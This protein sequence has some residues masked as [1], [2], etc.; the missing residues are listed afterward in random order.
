MSAAMRATVSPKAR[1]ISSL[2]ASLGS[3]MMPRWTSITKSAPLAEG[4]LQF[5][6]IGCAGSAAYV[7]IALRHCVN[8]ESLSH[9]FLA[10]RLPQ[11]RLLAGVQF[12][13]SRSQVQYI[14][15]HLPLRLDQCDFDIALMLR[16]LRAHTVKQSG[17]V[18]S[19]YLQQRASRRAAV[20]EFNLPLDLDLGTVRL[21]RLQAVAQHTRH[22]GF[23]FDPGHDAFFQTV[24]FLQVHLQRLKAIVEIESVYHR[25]RGIR[26]CIRF[27]DVHSP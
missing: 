16:D 19:D 22:V 6:K 2:R 9:E 17:T 23:A 7:G 8:E 5:N 15:R 13:P 18:L 4:I 20:V 26:K 25:A 10:Q 27:H 24:P 14:N 11:R 21:L 12:C 1:S 3:S